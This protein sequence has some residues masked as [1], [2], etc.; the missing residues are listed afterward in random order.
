MTP[1]KTDMPDEIYA[2]QDSTWS[3]VDYD[4][5]LGG[6]EKYTRTDIFKSREAELLAVIRDL[7][8]VLELYS[9]AQHYN[10]GPDILR[11]HADIIKQAREIE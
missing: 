11:K 3:V 7:A 9:N 10:N 1:Q 8:G 5:L 2:Q 6:A 4:Y